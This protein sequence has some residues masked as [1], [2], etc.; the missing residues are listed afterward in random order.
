MLCCVCKINTLKNNLRVLVSSPLKLDDIGCCRAFGTIDDIERDAG[1]FFSG[2][3]SIGLNCRMVYKHVFSFVL[4]NK[5]KTFCIVKPLNCTFG[6][7]LH[8]PGSGSP[9][10]VPGH[11]CSFLGSLRVCLLLNR[12]N[13]LGP[14]SLSRSSSPFSYEPGPCILARF[15]LRGSLL[16]PPQLTGGRFRFGLSLKCLGFG[17]GQSSF[18][19]N[20]LTS[21][22]SIADTKSM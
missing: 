20:H 15:S 13:K 9:L 16:R 21:G 8:L 17:M 12:D 19:L 2:L 10:L 1:P 3:K 11:P 22:H 18:C 5:S 6:H 14:R 4:L 7:F